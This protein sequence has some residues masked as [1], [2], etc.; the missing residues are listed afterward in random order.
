M[1]PGA[2]CEPVD[3]RANRA[4]EACPRGR[5]GH[6]P[7][8]TILLRDIL[9]PWHCPQGS[10]HGSPQLAFEGFHAEKLS[11][12]DV[13]P[14]SPRPGTLGV[15]ISPNASE[16]RVVHAADPHLRESAIDLIV[17]DSLDRTH[18]DDRPAW[19]LGLRLRLARP[20]LGRER[21]IAPSSRM[22][23][24][25]HTDSRSSSDDHDRRQVEGEAEKH[26]HGGRTDTPQHRMNDDPVA[27][28]AR[29]T[30]HGITNPGRPRGPPR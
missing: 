24:V 4:N 3:R 17:R 28:P 9:N 1:I 11:N 20:R 18:G 27:E 13:H 14:P 15:P 22:E 2:V 19:L 7:D 25:Q 6:D 23:D 5:P 8:L 29:K 10:V 26:Q 21:A 30:A 16:I 12:R